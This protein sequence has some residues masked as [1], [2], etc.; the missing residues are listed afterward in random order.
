[1]FIGIK[2]LERHKLTFREEFAPGTIDFRTGDFRQVA[3]LRVELEAELAGA[4]I[5][6]VGRLATRIELTCARCLEPVGQDLAP[7]FDLLYRPV[8]RGGSSGED[9]IALKPDNLEIGF[10]VDDGLFLGDVLAEQVHLALPM[11]V[12][13]REECRGLC[14]GCGANLNR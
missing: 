3:P 9:E 2:E 5:H 1:M 6:L 10:Y 4:E 8:P 7:S 11:K 12:V 14:P 13:C